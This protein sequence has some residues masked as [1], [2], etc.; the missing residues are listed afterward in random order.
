MLS[1]SALLVC[2]Q[3]LPADMRLFGE[4]SA[5]LNF[6]SDFNHLYLLVLVG[7][8]VECLCSIRRM[9]KNYDDLVF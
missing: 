8:T 5:D 9:F 7:Y 4:I 1:L 6:F 2:R 3:S